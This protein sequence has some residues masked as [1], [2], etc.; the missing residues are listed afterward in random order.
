MKQDW[1][2]TKDEWIEKF[3]LSHPEIILDEALERQI[4]GNRINH[5]FQVKDALE[6]G[7]TVSAAVLKDYPELVQHVKRSKGELMRF[8]PGDTVQVKQREK[9]FDLSK[10]TVISQINFE[11]KVL[12]PFAGAKNWLVTFEEHELN[13]LK[14]K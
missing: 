14:G 8:S 1:E 9:A 10:G 13:L 7:W 6:R 4:D 12:I 3:L 5:F 2:M 11:V